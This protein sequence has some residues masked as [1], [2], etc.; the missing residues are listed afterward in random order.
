M[1]IEIEVNVARFESTIRQKIAEFRLDL[2]EAALEAARAG[3]EEA[4]RNHPYQDRTGV[5]SGYQGTD[6]PEYR[7]P[8]TGKQSATAAYQVRD[9]GEEAAEMVWPAFYASFVDKG[10]GKSRPYPFTPQAE[11]VAEETLKKNVERS[12]EKLAAKVG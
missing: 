1:S 11:R 7:G 5:L 8:S 10:T 3:I 12:I 2:R 9:A 6:S 4:R